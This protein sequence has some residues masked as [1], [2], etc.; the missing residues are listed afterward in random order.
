MAII[1]DGIGGFQKRFP[2]KIW[3]WQHGLLPEIDRDCAEPA[4]GGTSDAWGG[5]EEDTVHRKTKHVIYMEIMP[6]IK[7]MRNKQTRPGSGE[8]CSVFP[9]QRGRAKHCCLS[10]SFCPSQERGESG[11]C[12]FPWQEPRT[13][14]KHDVEGRGDGVCEKNVR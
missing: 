4:C 11:T 6:S 13:R 1:R 3:G 12:T 5:I 9:Q 8:S 14:V 7:I 10:S 2:T